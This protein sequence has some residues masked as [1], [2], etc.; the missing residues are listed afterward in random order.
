M[1][2]KVAPRPMTCTLMKSVVIL[3][4]GEVSTALCLVERVWEWSPEGRICR[5]TSGPEVSTRNSPGVIRPAM[6]L[7]CCDQA[8]AVALA[9][10]QS[11]ASVGAALGGLGRR[12][13]RS[14]P[15]AWRGC[16]GSVSPAN[17]ATSFPSDGFSSRSLAR[18]FSASS[19]AACNVAS[20]AATAGTSPRRMPVRKESA[21]CSAVRAKS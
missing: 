9:R 10:S 15:E 7:P 14:K 12:P 21:I 8:V 18:S 20:L 5:R 13:T 1:R 3:K 19:R 11:G 6:P 17:P 4:R 2:R 16:V